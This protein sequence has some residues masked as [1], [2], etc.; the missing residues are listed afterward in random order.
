MADTTIIKVVHVISS[1]KL[2]GAETVLY[3]IVKNLDPKKFKQYVVYFHDGPIRKQI[4][5]LQIETIN[6][7]GSLLRYDFI[8][9]LRL[10]KIIKKIKPDIIH[11]SL[12]SANFFGSFVSKFLKIPIVSSLHALQE[13]EGFIRNQLNKLI[14]GRF[15]HTSKHSIIAV[16]ESV[17]KSFENKNLIDKAQINIISNCLD[18]SDIIE[19]SKTHSITRQSLNIADNDFV[20]GS[21]GRFV[22][23]K[24]YNILID[25][26][27]D[28]LQKYP[29]IKLVLVG[30]G[31]EYQ[32]L[33]NQ[34]IKLGL[35][36]N[37]HFI[38]GEP[39]YKFYQIF[40]CFAQPSAYEGLSVA[41]LE[42]LCFKLPCIVTGLDRKHDV[43]KDNYNGL[44][45]EPNNIVQLTG[46]LETIINNLE[47][48]KKL[49][50]N[51][52]DTLKNSFDIKIMINKYEQMFKEK[53]GFKQNTQSP[54]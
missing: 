45:I 10:I 43:I 44:I 32:N 24:N 51:G 17:A 48:A 26:F 18:I 13:H 37:I 34:V 50:A 3:S 39:G 19:K 14:F 38:I 29:N 49:G 7:S 6:I 54:I 27:Y 40:D 42:A 41:L 28:L 1:L 33:K 46:S 20:I 11:S 36:D 16:S 5:Q 30:V 4:E 25:S 35:A 9:M 23:V 12:W 8:F 31:P 15:A 47:W 53:S 22:K 52:F 2:G 21:V